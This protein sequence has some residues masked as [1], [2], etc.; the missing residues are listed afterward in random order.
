MKPKNLEPKRAE[1]LLEILKKRFDKNMHRHPNIDWEDVKPKLEASAEKL[2]S[3]NEM[4][5]SDGEPDVVSIYDNEEIIFIDCAAESPKGRRSLCYDEEA[6]ESRKEHKPKDSAVNLAKFMGVKMLN[7]EEYAALQSLGHFDA[8]T[9]SWLETPSEIR[10]KGGAIFGDYR[11]GRVFT[12][13]NGAESYYAARGFRG[14][15]SLS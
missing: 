11:F 2:W 15:I 12:Y 5:E 3:I 14:L 1:E 9:S 7:E 6:L 8:K 10:E 4:E 13:H